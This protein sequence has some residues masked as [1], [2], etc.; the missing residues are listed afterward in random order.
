MTFEVVLR[1]TITASWAKKPRSCVKFS[2]AV[3]S[4]RGYRLAQ[5]AHCP[6]HTAP[7]ILF[8]YAREHH[9]H[10]IRAAFREPEP[11]AG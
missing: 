10:G 9:Q 4:H 6:A 8:P 5:M 11:C 1:V 7:N 3:F 2:R